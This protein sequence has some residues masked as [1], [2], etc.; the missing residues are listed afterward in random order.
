MHGRVMSTGLSFGLSI[1]TFNTFLRPPMAPRD[2]REQR[3]PHM[4]A[5]LQRQFPGADAIILTEVFTDA[6]AEQL[7]QQLTRAY[8]VPW[9]VSKA[10]RG[11]LLTLPPQFVSGGVRIATPHRVVTEE[12]MSYT[13]RCASTADAWAGKGAVYAALSVH[14]HDVDVFGTHLQA[15]EGTCAD[16]ARAAQLSELRRFMDTHRRSTAVCVVGGDFN[17]DMTEARHAALNT[18]THTLSMREQSTFDPASNPLVGLDGSAQ[19][20]MPEYLQSLSEK[21]DDTHCSC[22]SPALYDYVLVCRDKPYISADVRVTPLLADTPFVGKLPNGGT[23]TTR[24]LSDH[25][26]I[27][28]EFTFFSSLINR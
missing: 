11:R 10:P 5:A 2:M 21:G 7:E 25:H 23:M 9:R 19:Q 27:V 6:H 18:V 26:A 28:A 3:L 1:V 16:D 13:A 8:G 17:M 12:R 20:C 4:G 15:W 14:G 22:C 24:F